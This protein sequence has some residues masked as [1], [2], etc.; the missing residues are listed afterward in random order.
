MYRIIYKSAIGQQLSSK[1]TEFLKKW[2]KQKESS[3]KSHKHI[4]YKKYCKI[5]IKKLSSHD[6]SH[7]S[8]QYTN[9]MKQTGN[10]ALNDLVVELNNFFDEKV[11]T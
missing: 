6:K 7:L 2:S 4:T 1:Q 9:F 11:I 5:P 8:L 3:L 10:L